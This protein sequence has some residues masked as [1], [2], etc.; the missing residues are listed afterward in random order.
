MIDEP[1]VHQ[2][3]NPTH[4]KG[5]ANLAAGHANSVRLLLHVFAID[6]EAHGAP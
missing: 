5:P 6:F 4:A 2:R 1:D 3:F